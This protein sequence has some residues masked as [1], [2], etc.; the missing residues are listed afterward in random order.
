MQS[1]VD[2]TKL[3]EL[4]ELGFDPSL[5]ANSLAATDNNMEAAVEWYHICF[6]T[7]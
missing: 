2:A 6:N 4:Q 3:K 7:M 5:C 1:N